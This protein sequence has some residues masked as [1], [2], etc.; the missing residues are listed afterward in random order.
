MHQ[1]KLLDHI[2]AI[3]WAFNVFIV[4]MQEAQF[5]PT[6]NQISH[7]R[8]QYIPQDLS[9]NRPRATILRCFLPFPGVTASLPYKNKEYLLKIVD[10]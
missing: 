1:M 10:F 9:H 3:D 8:H 6:T 4:S 7:L 5:M 2:I